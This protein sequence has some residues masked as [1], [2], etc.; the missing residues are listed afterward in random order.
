MKRVCFYMLLMFLTTQIFSQPIDSIEIKLKKYKDLFEQGLINETDYTKLKN[1]LLDIP[2]NT[3]SE[4]KQFSQSSIDSMKKQFKSEIITGGVFIVGGFAPVAAGIYYKKNKIP[5]ISNYINRSGNLDV[6]RYNS[7][8][9]N[10][11]MGYILMFSSGAVLMGAGCVL[12]ILGI[13]RK[14][15][16]L[17]KYK[18]VSLGLTNDGIGVSFCIK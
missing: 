14:S 4:S 9:K 6:D 8:I 5:S 12:E 13:H 16:Y 1:N 11:R 2:S 18:N 3:Y 7:A 17:N 15:V 10:Y